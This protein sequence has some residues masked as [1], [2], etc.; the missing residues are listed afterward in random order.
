MV[1][2]GVDK[3]RPRAAEAARGQAISTI[4]IAAASAVLRRQFYDLAARGSRRHFRCR[5]VQ[6]AATKLS[7]LSVKHSSI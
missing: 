6:E 2:K 4:A 7:R 1:G 3:K 5:V